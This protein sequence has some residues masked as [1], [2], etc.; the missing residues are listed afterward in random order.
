MS[1]SRMMQ[2]LATTAFMSLFAAYAAPAHA[3]G[4]TGPP[5]KLC[6]AGG[7]TVPVPD[8]FTVRI[9]SNLSGA[10]TGIAGCLRPDWLDGVR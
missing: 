8:Y 6:R 7:I 4:F 2:K 10:G 1:R 5:T 3:D 9:C